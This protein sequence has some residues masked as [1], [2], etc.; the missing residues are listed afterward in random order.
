MK[1]GCNIA[2]IG[3]GAIGVPIADLLYKKYADQFYL[4]ASG[5]IRQNL[6][7]TEITING[8]RFTPKIV[9][10]KE[11]INGELDVLIVCVKNYDLESA[12]KDIKCVVTKK[13]KILP[14]QNGIF[15]YEFF[16]SKFPDRVVL[17]GYV[18]GPNTYWK[19]AA[20][21][22]QNA[23]AMHIGSSNEQWQAEA[24]AVYDWLKA[25]QID[26]YFETNIRYMVWKKWMLNVAGNSVT[27]LTGA[28]YSMF[29]Y[30][31][32][33]QQICISAME[34]FLKVAEAE[35]VPLGVNDI[36]DIIE[37][38]VSYNGSKKTSMLMDVLNERKTEND[39]LAGTL[40][41]I[42][43]RHALKLPVIHT[44]YKLVEAKERVYMEGKGCIMM[45]Y[46]FREG[47]TYS[48]GL[49][50]AMQDIDKKMSSVE[51][52]RSVNA[53]NVSALQELLKYAIHHTAYYSGIR[54]D[55]VCLSDFP[56][57]NKTILNEHY[58]EIMVHA[59]DGQPTHKMH[60]SGSTGIPF[61]VI[62]DLAK[63]ERHIADLKYFGTMAG[64]LD[65]DPMCYLRAKPTATLVEQERDNIWQ[66]D[67]C[68]LNEK[69]L[70]EYYHVMVEKKCTA[71][72]AYPSTLETA[73][74]FW[75]AHFTN[76]SCISTIISTSEALT[77]EVK[78]KLRAF[79][80]DNV[81]VYARY[82]NTENGILGQE[83]GKSGL[84]HLN[85][86]SYYF[87][88]LKLESDEPAEDGEL[89]RIVVTDLF[90]KA[91]PMI[92]YDTGDVA[93]MHRESRDKLPVLTE[94]YGR[95]MDLIYDTKGEVVSPFLLCRTMRLSKGI[96][97]WQFIQETA[98]EYTLRI[99][100]NTDV[101]P[102]CEKEVESFKRTLGADAVIRI[103]Y[104]E[105]IP[106]MNS[107]KRKLIVS[108]L[109]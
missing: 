5:A 46:L 92:R 7:A 12:L 93:K 83:I 102:S 101:K 55:G 54:E 1:A 108:N 10:T 79:F 105:N 17:E 75:S 42:A 14:L 26:V 98:T 33:L 60:T 16:K 97:Q 6:E 41:T 47:V 8:S 107:L 30:Y 87:E 78:D 100:A 11:E 103:E 19:E 2:L 40:L 27:A 77:D 13:T 9:S 23:G 81:G 43:E 44:L 22:Y 74:D 86:A 32:E 28:D 70:T 57:M 58:D 53:G 31:G 63:R 35:Q 109:Q 66:L 65:Q 67:I 106:V 49:K 18:Q 38:Y 89:G 71:L 48:D 39:Y 25:A 59:Y 62:Q 91:F 104:V 76:N 24:H 20:Y 99:T 21:Y 61:T 3:F 94:L 90:N 52:A 84:Y 56:V 88:I 73:V 34:E 85:W 4:I 96:E 45:K 64:Y 82:S 36:Q 69:N 72:M 51:Y 80:G 95:R 68:N 50:K 29:K 15:S 37:Y